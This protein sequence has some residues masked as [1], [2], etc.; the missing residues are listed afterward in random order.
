[1]GK[2]VS[3]SIKR[4]VESNQRTTYYV[5]AMNDEGFEMTLDAFSTGYQAGN[6]FVEG[7]SQDEALDRAATTAED[8]GDFL[9]ISPEPYGVDGVVVK[10]SFPLLRYAGLRSDGD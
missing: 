1:M 10:S 3:I 5:M 8:W 4:G 6:A 9:E 2:I 7:L